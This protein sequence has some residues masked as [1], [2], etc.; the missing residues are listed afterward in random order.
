M[1]HLSRTRLGLLPVITLLAACANTVTPKVTTT[2]APMTLMGEVHDNPDGHKQ[3]FDLLAARVAQGARPV[4]VMEQFD[5]DKSSELASAM[6]NC[7]DAPCVIAQAGGARWDWPLYYPVINLALRYQLPVIAAN[8]SRTEATK[9]RRE[10]WQAVLSNADMQYWQLPASISPTLRAGQETAIV[11]GHCNQRPP[12]AMLD[13]FVNAQIVRDIW[14]A[15]TMIAHA[16]KDVVLIA[17]NGHVRRD[18]GVPY[19]LAQQGYASVEVIGF[20]ESAQST[21]QSLT[22]AYYDT[23]YTIKSHA[24]PDPC[25]AFTTPAVLPT[26]GAIKQ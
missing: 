21:P 9:V 19:W 11:E 6:A 24:R 25:A 23:L 4:I 17:G 1:I 2:A 26:P 12:H 3:R 8:V 10:G 5:R 14:M 18:I 20:V 7:K 15:R 22:P 13:G 16:G